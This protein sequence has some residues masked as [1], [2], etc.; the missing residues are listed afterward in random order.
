[1]GSSGE[2]SAN[3]SYAEKEA[4]VKAQ[5]DELLEAVRGSGGKAILAG[6]HHRSDSA[7]GG[8]KPPRRFTSA[9]RSPEGITL[10]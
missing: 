2:E 5:R 6:D 10:I 1:M 8:K 7:G 4:A 9:R 3:T